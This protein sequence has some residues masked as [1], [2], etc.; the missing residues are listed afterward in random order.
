MYQGIYERLN[1]PITAT[2][3]D[4]RAKALT[5]LRPECRTSDEHKEGREA[6]IAKM[7]ECHHAAQRLF[8]EYRF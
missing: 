1:L 3:D 8:R 2:D 7:R 6:F 4:V 5:K